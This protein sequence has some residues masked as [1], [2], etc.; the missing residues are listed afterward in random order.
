MNYYPFH[1]GD[2]AAH[3][4]HLTWEED[5]AYRR[6]LDWY[7]LNEKALPLDTQKLARLIRMP[8]SMPAIETVLSEFFFESDDGWHNKRADEELTSMLSKQEQQATKDEHEAERMRR[9]RERRATMFAAL[10]TVGVV[11]AWDVAMKEL[12]RLHDQ[13]CNAPETQPA[14]DL[15]REQVVFGDE[16]ATAIPTPTPTPTPTPINSVTD[17]TGADVANGPADMTKDEL[18][19][20]GK[21][22]LEGAGIPKAQCGSIVGKLVKDY[23]DAIVVDAVRAA[24]LTR[25]ADPVEY[26]KAACMHAKGQRATPNRQVAVEQR[27]QAAVDAWL[28]Q[29]GVPA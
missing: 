3:T 4:A 5:I 12:Q 17:V 29:E 11:P 24:V 2:F 9:Y 16:P 28:Q 26:M 22:L 21:S 6:M 20:A 27:N 7:Y 19:K 15:Q 1:I 13:H 18:W 8:K 10:R 23:G 14:T 25:P